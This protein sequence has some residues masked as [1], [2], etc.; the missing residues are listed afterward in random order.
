[1]ES[2]ETTRLLPPRDDST[3]QR[4]TSYARGV[5]CVIA[6]LLGKLDGLNRREKRILTWKNRC[7]PS[8]GGRITHDLHVHHRR[9]RSPQLARGILAADQLQLG[10]LD[11]TSNCA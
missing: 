7:V 9:L 8:L 10:L 4:A 2:Q 11:S 3:S 5:L 6:T 1:M